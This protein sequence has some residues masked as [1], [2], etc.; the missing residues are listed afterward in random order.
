MAA[1][2]QPTDLMD[3]PDELLLQITEC[4]HLIRSDQ[5]QSQAFKSKE[6]ERSRQRENHQRQ[7]ALYALCLT[8]RRLNRMAEPL[9]Y[10]AFLGSSTWRGFRPI[11]LFHQTV[12]DRPGLARH[13]KYVENRLSDYLGNGLYDDMEF[14]G[15]VDMVQEYFL[16]LASIVGH[17]TN[18][19]HLSVVS[20]ETADVSFWCHIFGNELHPQLATH[21]FPKLQTL[22][23][24]IQTEG[25]GLGDASAWFRR[26]ANELTNVPTLTSLRASG[27]VTSGGSAPL[28]GRYKLLD[29]VE[30][31]DAI[32]E[33]DEV[34]H[35]T[36]ACENLKHFN[37]HWAFLNCD[38][39][40]QPSDLYPG[41]SPHKD[42]LETLHLDVREARFHHG[43][44]ALEPLGSLRG[45]TALK[46]VSI[47]TT[48]LLATDLSI[49]DFPDQ[50]LP[51]R[52][53]QLL[54]P[55][56]ESLTL[57]LQSDHGYDDDFRIDEAFALWDLAE[58]CETMLP[59][60]KEF[61]IKSGHVLAALNLTK[62]FKEVGIDLRFIK[63]EGCRQYV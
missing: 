58:D 11:K 26:I 13:V 21:G 16:K 18:I 6:Q 32:L 57:L 14:Y 9:L 54:P 33:F 25:Y 17:A 52:I 30:I 41:L 22:C 56:L 3:L 28:V 51:W 43:P 19:Q 46:F 63:E 34:M 24:Q 29:T 62:Q 50:H 2:Y 48:T 27:V 55:S 7:K 35:L 45:F 59:N 23:L 61:H 39:L 60:L 4:L 8:S 15:A 53:A 10:S 37:C 20:L 12:S 42:T 38:G 49:L 40:S 36:S 1:V 5:P 44:F 31:S 47:C